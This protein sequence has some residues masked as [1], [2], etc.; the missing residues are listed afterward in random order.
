[1]AIEH[2]IRTN[3]RSSTQNRPRLLKS[4]TS[5]CTISLKSTDFPRH[6]I[7]TID[8]EMTNNDEKMTTHFIISQRC[9]HNFRRHFIVTCH[10][11]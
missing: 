3:A 4:S 11:K 8:E 6:F 7:I 10:V 1:M 2:Q 9:R 5:F